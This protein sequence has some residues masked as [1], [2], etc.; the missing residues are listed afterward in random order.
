[1]TALDILRDHLK[2]AEAD[3]LRGLRLGAVRWV[4]AGYRDT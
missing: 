1:M 2:A 3:A 4:E